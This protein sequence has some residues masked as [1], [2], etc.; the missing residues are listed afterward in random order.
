MHILIFLKRCK[1]VQIMKKTSFSF[2]HISAYL[3]ACV[4]KNV[5]N[6]NRSS[7]QNWNYNNNPWWFWLTFSLLFNDICLITWE[8][9]VFFFL[10]CK[11]VI[12]MNSMTNTTFPPWYGVIS[13]SLRIHGSLKVWEFLTAF[14]GKNCAI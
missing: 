11:C 2:L 5:R 9:T 3:G 8:L 1:D 10:T 7:F 4:Y 6:T 12:V 13:L 14:I